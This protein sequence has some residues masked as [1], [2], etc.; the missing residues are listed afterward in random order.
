MID[1]VHRKATSGKSRIQSPVNVFRMTPLAAAVIAAL[2]PAGAA[3]A[4]DDALS[5]DEILVTATKR[6]ISLQDVPH[7]I[8]VL[9]SVQLERMGAKDLEATLRALPSVHLTALQP[10]QNQLSVRGMTS[11]VYEYRREAQVAV[12]L[13]EQPMTSNAQQVGIRNIDMARV[14]FLP[15]P[16]GTLFGSSSQTG[17][18]RYITNE[19]NTDGFEGRIEGRWGTT[20]GGEDSYDISGV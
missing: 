18:L 2:G 1:D 13:D 5:I 14:E 15:G 20:T 19:P 16:Q 9:S 10:G 3:V 4:Q 6:E 11:E 8:D 12:Y 17:T 7:S